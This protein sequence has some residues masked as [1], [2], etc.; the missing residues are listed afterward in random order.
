MGDACCSTTMGASGGRP[1]AWIRCA[2]FAVFLG[3]AESFV[4][5]TSVW[6]SRPKLPSRTERQSTDSCFSVHGE[7]FLAGL[8]GITA[9]QA[10][11]SLATEVMSMPALR[12]LVDCAWPMVALSFVLITCRRGDHRHSPFSFFRKH[13]LFAGLS[14]CESFVIAAACVATS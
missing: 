11:A 9:T 4:V 12:E 7:T 2:L 14:L 1:S 6:S 8:L 5:S 10:A 3:S 13:S